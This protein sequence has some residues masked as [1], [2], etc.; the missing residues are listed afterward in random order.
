MSYSLL[1]GWMVKLQWWV[2]RLPRGDWK[3]ELG[4]FTARDWRRNRHS[5]RGRRNRK[6]TWLRVKQAGGSGSQKETAH[7]LHIHWTRFLRL[8]LCQMPSGRAVWSLETAVWL[9][10]WR[11]R[12]SPE[13]KADEWRSG[14]RGSAGSPGEGSGGSRQSAPARSDRLPGQGSRKDK[15]PLPP[16]HVRTHGCSCQPCPDSDWQ[17]RR[18]RSRADA[19]QPWKVTR[20]C[21]WKDNIHFPGSKIIRTT[22][23]KWHINTVLL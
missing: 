19:V 15:A 2:H 10:C 4:E 13:V 23:Q 3:E 16:G 20:S 5:G 18:R 17:W 6:R 14:H 22:P 7:L 12:S 11:G 8:V 9:R 21:Y 1:R